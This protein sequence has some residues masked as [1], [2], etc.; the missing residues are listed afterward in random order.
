MTITDEYTTTI[1]RWL[2]A[3]WYGQAR[4]P[5]GRDND[6]SVESSMSGIEA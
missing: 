6:W 2:D 1:Q 5:T 3:H 4:C